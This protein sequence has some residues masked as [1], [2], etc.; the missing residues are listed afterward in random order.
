M[1]ES[2]SSISSLLRLGAYGC[3]K[4]RWQLSNIIGDAY[5]TFHPD[6]GCSAA[7]KCLECPWSVCREDDHRAFQRMQ[8]VQADRERLAS[9]QNL[10]T[11]EAAKVLGVEP[12]TVYR[13]MRRIKEASCASWLLT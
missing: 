13:M 9:V 11:E 3:H 5:L 2:C 12:R 4:E 10:P 8:K 6:T 7:P 1:A